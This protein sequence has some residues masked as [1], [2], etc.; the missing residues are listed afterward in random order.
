M[1]KGGGLLRMTNHHLAQIWGSSPS[2]TRA[3]CMTTITLKNLTV[4]PTILIFFGKFGKNLPKIPPKVKKNSRFALN[5]AGSQ[6]VLL[7]CA[8]KSSLQH[9]K[10]ILQLHINLCK[11]GCLKALS[12]ILDGQ[13]A[14]K[15]S[16]NITKIKDLNQVQTLDPVCHHHPN[17]LKKGQNFGI[18]MTYGQ[19]L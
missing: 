6:M 8:L 7:G 18:N 3:A 11:I 9:Y 13:Q 17:S 1:G 2:L 15:M 10:R 4:W 16:C 19:N 14:Y 5:W 12:N